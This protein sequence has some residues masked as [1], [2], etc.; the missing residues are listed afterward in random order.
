MANKETKK[1][2]ADPVKVSV[3]EN[4]SVEHEVKKSVKPVLETE[5]KPKTFT[6]RDLVEPK[7]AVDEFFLEDRTIEAEKLAMRK[8][9]GMSL[10]ENHK[11]IKM[12]FFDSLKFR[13]YSAGIKIDSITFLNII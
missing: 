5:T 11:E 7:T 2:V 13:I 6:T 10:P 8:K 3:K 4:L 9:L 12:G 1:S